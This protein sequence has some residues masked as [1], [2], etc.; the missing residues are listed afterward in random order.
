MV[1]FR[2]KIFGIG[3]KVIELNGV[4]FAVDRCGDGV[5]LAKIGL[6]NVACAHKEIIT[7]YLIA[8]KARRIFEPNLVINGFLSVNRN[9]NKFLARI[10]RIKSHRRN[11]D[12]FNAR[13]GIDKSVFGRLAAVAGNEQ[14]R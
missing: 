8:K 11:V 1:K 3:K 14:K 5:K 7:L 10:D 12:V 2:G 4:V 9:G 13:V 6:L